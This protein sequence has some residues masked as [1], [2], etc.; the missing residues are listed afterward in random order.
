M[1]RKKSAVDSEICNEEA[2]LVGFLLSVQIRHQAHRI[3]IRQKRLT[4]VPTNGPTDQHSM[5]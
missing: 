4:N 2:V 3:H 5:L 1:I